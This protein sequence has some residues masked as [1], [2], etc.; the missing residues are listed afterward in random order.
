MPSLWYHEGEGLLYT[1]F[2]GNL[3][4]FGDERGIPPLS[5]WSFKPDGIGSGTWNELIT[6][7]ASANASVWNS[8]TRPV[9]GLMA[10]GPGNAWVLG[11]YDSGHPYQPLSGMMQFNMDSKS[12]QNI[13]VA[14]C[15]YGGHLKDGAMQHV[16]SFAGF[17]VIMGGIITNANDTLSDLETVSVFD[18]ATARCFNQ[19][20]TGSPPSPRQQFCTAGV[21][22]TNGTYEM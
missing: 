7:N 17:F 21:N 3:A 14:D 2:A 5:L 15:I 13:S 1:G 19:T 4:V 18:P 11:G 9:E 22:S 12:F 6:S 8:I 10:Y 16:S 20:T